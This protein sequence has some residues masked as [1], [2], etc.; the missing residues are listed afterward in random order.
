VGDEQR[1]GWVGSTDAG[2]VLF[3]ITVRRRGKVR[4]VT[5]RDASNAA[6][7]RYRQRGK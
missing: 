1:S 2:R 7:R 5:A 4:V 3:L 6:K